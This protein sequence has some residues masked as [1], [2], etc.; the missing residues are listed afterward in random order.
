VTCWS[1]NDVGK[2]NER[3]PD[4]SKSKV[5]QIKPWISGSRV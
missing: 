1:P 4:F 2:V 5:A 3:P